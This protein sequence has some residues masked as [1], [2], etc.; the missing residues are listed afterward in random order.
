MINLYDIAYRAG[1]WAS[2]PVWLAR[3][4]SRR[5]VM[6]ALQQRN[7]RGLPPVPAGTRGTILV[8]AVSLGEMNATRA[9]IAKLRESRPGLQFVVSA[10]TDTGFARGMELY[11]P[12][13][14]VEVIRYPLDFSGAVKRVLRSEEHTSELQSPMY[15][16]CRL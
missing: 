12:A 8:H 4:S 9:L 15:L 11:G 7:G 14:D 13:K 16:V 5:K 10:T 2:A 6:S 3:E 1:L